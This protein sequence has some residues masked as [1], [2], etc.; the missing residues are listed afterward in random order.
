MPLLFKG[1]NDITKKNRRDIQRHLQQQGVIAPLP[2]E[3][4]HYTESGITTNG[5]FFLLS[6]VYNDE[7]AFADA[8]NLTEQKRNVLSLIDQYAQC[9]NQDTRLTLQHQI[10]VACGDE[11]SDIALVMSRKGIDDNDIDPENNTE[12]EKFGFIRGTRIKL[13]DAD[14]IIA[15]D[16]DRSFHYV[17]EDRVF[18]AYIFNNEADVDEECIKQYFETQHNN[19]PNIAHNINVLKAFPI[20]YQMRIAMMEQ[21]LTKASDTLEDE[22]LQQKVVAVCTALNNCTLND[23]PYKNDFL[24]FKYTCLTLQLLC[25]TPGEERNRLVAEYKKCALELR[26]SKVPGLAALGAAMIIL[27]G[28]LVV[29]MAVMT[30]GVAPIILLAAGVTAISSGFLLAAVGTYRFF[31]KNTSATRDCGNKMIKLDNHIANSEED[32]LIPSTIDDGDNGFQ[33]N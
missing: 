31:S 8:Q 21:Y 33:F 10:E 14:Q 22:E 19:V 30:P 2:E 18:F 27:G 15:L 20:M 29:T 13:S 11:I 26:G 25:S 1:L 17:S 7:R 24:K 16:N 6:M 23:D 3:M 9:T 12:S 32:N 28:A 4:P 5:T